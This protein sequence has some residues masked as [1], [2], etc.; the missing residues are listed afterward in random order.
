[1]ILHI[2]N[3]MWPNFF[4]CG[5]FKD[6]KTLSQKFSCSHD[7]VTLHATGGCP[8]QEQVQTGTDRGTREHSEL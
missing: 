3:E 7:T 5:L 1:M 8:L 2:K 6:L 4:M